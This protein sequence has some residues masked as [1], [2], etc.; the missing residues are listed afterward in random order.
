[1][2][3]CIY[4]KELEYRNLNP[5]VDW[6]HLLSM[7]DAYSSQIAKSINKPQLQIYV[8]VS[9]TN[10]SDYGWCMSCGNGI[11]Q[12]QFSEF[13]L[14]T[15]L[16]ENI[17]QHELC[18]AYT[19]EYFPEKKT[20]GPNFKKLTDSI[21]NHHKVKKPWVNRLEDVTVDTYKDGTFIINFDKKPKAHIN[22]GM[23]IFVDGNKEPFKHENTI[24]IYYAIL[25]KKL[26]KKRFF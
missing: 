25:C 1:M 13:V 15:P 20:H 23:G 24:H 10:K 18:H 7:V 22:F 14:G 17:I 16:E 9:S 19:C 6:N 12:L 11:Y 4:E 8:K 2:K 5:D 21:F 26:G 3:N